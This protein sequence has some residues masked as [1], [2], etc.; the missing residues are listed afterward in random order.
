MKGTAAA[1]ERFKDIIAKEERHSSANTEPQPISAPPTH[2][3]LNT[4]ISSDV[5]KPT[6]ATTAVE[7]PEANVEWVPPSGNLLI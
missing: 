1:L 5:Q 7:D 2:E 6:E 3:T 4:A